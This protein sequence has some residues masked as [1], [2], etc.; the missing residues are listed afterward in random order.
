MKKSDKRH[1]SQCRPRWNRACQDQGS[2]PQTKR[3]L[4]AGPSADDIKW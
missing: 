2:E 4:Q 1:H 3:D